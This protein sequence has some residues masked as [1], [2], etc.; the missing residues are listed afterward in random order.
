MSEI[1]QRSP[2]S[3]DT[4]TRLQPEL[5]GGVRY[6]SGLTVYD[7]A[8]TDGRLVGRYWSGTGTIKPLRHIDEE[9]EVFA[10]VPAAAFTVRIDDQVL[11][12]DW[13][14]VGAHEEREGPAS[15]RHVVV[16]LAQKARP[17]VLKVHIGH[18]DSDL[19]GCVQAL[20]ITARSYAAHG[21]PEHF[22]TDIFTGGHRWSGRT[23]FAWL[24]RWL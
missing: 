10:S 13:L 5:T 24:D 20:E 7:E 11:D 21:V 4:A 6:R 17:V 12:G 8:L 16:E 9:A 22:D 18:L 15:A 19:A 23:S 3:P 1:S 14:W 2:D